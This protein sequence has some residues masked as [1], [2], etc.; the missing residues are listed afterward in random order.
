MP[1]E[2]HR[3]I[4][5]SIE[6]FV[7]SIEVDGGQMITVPQWVLPAGARQGHMLRVTHERPS[8]GGRSVLT[9]ELDEAAT[10]RAMMESAEQVRKTAR[11][12]G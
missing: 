4:V 12:S 1:T 10:H 9:I 8:S 3:W 5:D 6:E 7:A 2:G 11:R